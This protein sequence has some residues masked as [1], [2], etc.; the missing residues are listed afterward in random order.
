MQ[1]RATK[2]KKEGINKTKHEKTTTKRLLP[3]F[4]TILFPFLL[5]FFQLLNSGQ[6]QQNLSPFPPPP[7][8]PQNTKHKTQKYFS[9]SSTKTPSIF[10]RYQAKPLFGQKCCSYFIIFKKGNKKR[11]RKSCKEKR[12]FFVKNT[13]EKKPKTSTKLVF[14]VAWK[15]PQTSKVVDA[16]ISSNFMGQMNWWPVV[17]SPVSWCAFSDA[18]FRRQRPTVFPEIHLKS[19]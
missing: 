2:K 15:E 4:H 18:S 10:W 17:S 9:W 19:H 12:S 6:Q 1:W 13:E 16:K 11:S 8:S 3:Y 14:P 5:F 7:S